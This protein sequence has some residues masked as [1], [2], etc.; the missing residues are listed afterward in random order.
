ML[1]LNCNDT[2]LGD[3]AMVVHYTALKRTTQKRLLHH[4]SQTKLKIDTI[5]GKKNYFNQTTEKH[6]IKV[7]TNNTEKNF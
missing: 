5:L 1:K 3:I 2:N 4:L 7:S 6:T